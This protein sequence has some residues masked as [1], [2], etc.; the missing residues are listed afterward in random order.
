MY[1]DNNSYC[2]SCSTCNPRVGSASSY[3]DSDSS[4]DGR[5]R[6]RVKYVPSCPAYPRQHSFVVDMNNRPVY[7]M[8]KKPRSPKKSTASLPPRRSA[9]QPPPSAGCSLAH[10]PPGPAVKDNSVYYPPK[11]PFGKEVIKTSPFVFD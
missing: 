11:S 2:E 9:S 6:S 10:L 7:E 8:D 4:D 5:K 3:S 1:P